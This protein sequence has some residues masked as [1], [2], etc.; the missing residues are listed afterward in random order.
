M[1]TN[2]ISLFPFNLLPVITALLFTLPASEI[3]SQQNDAENKRVD[4][5]V[6]YFYDSAHHWYDI[7]EEQRMIDPVKDQQRFNKN[8]FEKIADNIL[9]FQKSNGGWAK[10]YDMLAMLSDEQMRSVESSRHSINTTF[11]NGTT[12]SQTDYLAKVYYLTGK[13]K[14]HDGFLKGI[15]FILKAQYPNGGWPQ[16]YPDTSG[17]RKYITFNDGA[18]SGIMIILTKMVNKVSYYNFLDDSLYNKIVESYKRGI[19]CILNCQIKH[20]GILTVWCQQHDNIDLTPRPARTFEP[21]AI[22]NGE[23]TSIVDLLMAIENPD[24]RIIN[25]V[26]SAVK[27]F[28]VS[29]IKGIKV[30]VVPADSIDF[31]YHTSSEDRVVVEDSSAPPIWTRFYEL[32]TLQPMFCTRA[33]KIVYNLSEVERERRT[34]YAWYIYDPQRIINLYPE[35]QKKWS[36]K[37]NVL[38]D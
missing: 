25:S 4:L 29:A 14:Y 8:E 33:G 26:Q 9:L 3:L 35:W 36:P 30:T 17:Y 28:K 7:R 16:Y 24:E 32:Y 6:S 20:N 13:Q 38:D 37:N 19:N 5:D 23:S 12:Y 21:A 2:Q 31:L 15:N 1:K 27:W 22:C 34:G 10:N 18:M 11:D